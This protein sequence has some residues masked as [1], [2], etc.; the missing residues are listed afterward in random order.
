MTR[1]HEAGCSLV[2]G[3]QTSPASRAE[4]ERAGRRPC[5]LCF[6]GTPPNPR[7]IQ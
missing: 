1:F 4:H 3:K 6:R 5:G 7:G 2:A